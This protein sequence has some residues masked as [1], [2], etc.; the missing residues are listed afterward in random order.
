MG[1]FNKIIKSVFTKLLVVIFITGICINFVVVGFFWSYRA[2]AGRPFHRNI[3]QYANYVIE[4]LG[5]PP[6]YQKA[7]EIARQASLQIHY[8]GSKTTWSTTGE[9]P[10]LRKMHLH[11]FHGG[12]NVRA[13]MYHGRF[14]LEFNHQNGLFIFEAAGDYEKDPALKWLLV[15]LLTLLTLILLGAYFSIRRILRPIKWLDHGVQEVSKGNLS[16]KVPVK[17]LD[18]LGHLTEAFNEMTTRLREMLQAKERLLQDVSHE[19]R[20]PLTRMK[21]ALEFLSEGKPRESIHADVVEME[22]MITAI[23]ESAR[24][25]HAHTRLNLQRADLAEL[26][27]EV[28]RAYQDHRPG[29]VFHDASSPATCEIDPEEIKTVLKNIMDNAVKY[30]RAD[31]API[32]IYLEEASSSLIIRIKDDGTGIS[33]DELPFIMEPFYRADKSRSKDTGGYGLGLSLCKRIVEAHGGKIEVDST[34]RKG[35]TVSLFLPAGNK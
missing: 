35:T 31:S 6:S 12:H 9:I 32:D 33:E 26:I 29:V 27:N 2:L 4:D 19:L 16:H 30:S 10:D 14:F 13:G 17:K 7:K 23:L 8:R 18:E 15:I 5:S 28:I 21:V 22:E 25:H 20:T 24:I 11:G 34:P 1:W 3:V